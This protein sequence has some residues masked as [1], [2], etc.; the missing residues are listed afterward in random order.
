[1]LSQV[2]SRPV[3]ANPYAYVTNLEER[4]ALFVSAGRNAFAN[5]LNQSFMQIDHLKQQVKSLS[6][7]GTLDRGYAVIRDESGHV[8]SDA[9]KVKT[10]TKLKLRLAKGD[11]GATA[12]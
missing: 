1:M 8:L 10:G 12:D 5:V 3:L 6:P 9:S 7:Q 11:L 2:R 4:L